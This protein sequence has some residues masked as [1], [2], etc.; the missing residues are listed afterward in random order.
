MCFP[1]RRQSLLGS[2]WTLHKVGLLCL[3]FVIGAVLQSERLEAQVL[4]QGSFSDYYFS[5]LEQNRRPPISVEEYIFDRYYYRRETV[6]PY[7]SLLRSDPFGRTCYEAYVLPELSR[8][9]A[10]APQPVVRSSPQYSIE[11]FEWR[12]R[13][14][15]P[16]PRFRREVTKCHPS[17][18]GCD[19]FG[20]GYGIK[21][22]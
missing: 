14:V 7:L 8:R 1:I 17:W 9:A 12:T 19:N 20:T 13:R 16:L 22:P 2:L 11:P 4:R 5:N 3:A 10:M 15:T 18:Y 21:S 6:S